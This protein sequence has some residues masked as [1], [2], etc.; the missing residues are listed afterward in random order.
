MWVRTIMSVIIRTVGSEPPPVGHAPLS[1]PG[2]GGCGSRPRG[3]GDLVEAMVH[4]LAVALDLSCLDDSK[5]SLRP[6]SPCAKRRDKLN[7]LGTKLGIGLAEDSSNSN[8]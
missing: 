6:E 8:T 5:Q 4:G 1:P 7:R 2:C 3:L